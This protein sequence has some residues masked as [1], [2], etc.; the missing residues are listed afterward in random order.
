[1][2]LLDLIAKKR[3]GGSHT[4]EELE[5]I[6]SCAS[7]KGGQAP[8]YQ[9]AAWLMAVVWR[10]MS[11]AETV[12]WTKAMAGS[13]RR[14]DL[15]SIKA[16]KVDKHSTGG[17]GDGISLALA[18]LVASA[19]VVVPMMSG[20]GL[21]HTGGT[22]DKLE[23]CR[24]FKVRLDV[25]QVE[26]QL[27][28][29]GV[30]MFGQ[31]EDLAP[32]DRKLYALRDAT[33]TVQSLPLIVG[34]ILSKKLAEDLGALIL[35]IKC[36]SGAIFRDKAQ[37]LVLGRKLVATSKKLGLKC[38]GLVTG[39]DQPLG[40]VVGNA[41]ELRQAIEVLQGDCTAGDYVELT[42]EL[43]GWMV[44]LAGKARDWKAG[45]RLLEERI[46]DGSAVEKL[47]EMIKAQGGDPKVVDDP[48]R[49]LPR[50]P[51][52]AVIAAPSSGYVTG[53]DARAIGVAAVALGAGRNRMEDA[54]DYGAGIRLEKKLGDPVKKGE[55]VARLFARDRGRVPGAEAA[56]AAALA[57]GRRKPKIPPLV[58]EVIR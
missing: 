10:G 56:F 55:P 48:D 3:D 39:M 18:P 12:A 57:V 53:L 36:G 1:M 50:S 34:S 30:C 24:G 8:D 11:D 2:R 7:G 29:L 44:H 42:L 5:F 17:V 32:A 20:R 19:G 28:H 33:A 35:D 31:T 25:P 13:G 22:L 51:E 47:R 58:R 52:A 46:K 54:I 14:L 38:V 27:S 15:G 37:A 6:A 40:R 16:P 4:P 23:S 45:A 43:G 41:L 26:R 21:G 9:L 49:A